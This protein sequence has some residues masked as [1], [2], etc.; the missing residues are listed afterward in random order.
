MYQPSGSMAGSLRP[1]TRSAPFSPIIMAP[2]L[3]FALS[4]VGMIEASMTGETN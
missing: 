4:M 3:R 1:L 2:A